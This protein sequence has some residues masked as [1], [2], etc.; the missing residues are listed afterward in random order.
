MPTPALAPSAA[1]TMTNCTSVEASPGEIDSINSRALAAVADDTAIFIDGASQ[2]GGKF[3]ALGLLGI[4]EHCR[5]VEGW[6]LREDN[7]LKYLACA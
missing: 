3:A 5:D 4:E 6:P 1:A 2:R 7:A